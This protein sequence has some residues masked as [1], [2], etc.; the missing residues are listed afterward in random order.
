MKPVADVHE[1]FRRQRA[2]RTFTDEDVPDDSSI[3]Y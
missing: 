1:L 2:I 3:G